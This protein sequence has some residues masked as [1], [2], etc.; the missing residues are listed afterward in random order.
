MFNIYIKKGSYCLK[1]KYFVEWYKIEVLENIAFTYYY[2]KFI[3][4]ELLKDKNGTSIL[5]AANTFL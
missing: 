3:K 4:S 2:Y 1:K 5:L